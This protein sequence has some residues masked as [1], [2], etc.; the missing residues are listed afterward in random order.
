MCNYIHCY[1]DIMLIHIRNFLSFLL[2]WFVL[3]PFL[4][5]WGNASSIWAKCLLHISVLLIFLW[6][7]ALNQGNT[8]GEFS[9]TYRIMY[10]LFSW[11]VN[12]HKWG[13]LYLH[14]SLQDHT[15]A[16][17]ILHPNNF[18]DPWILYSGCSHFSVMEYLT[19]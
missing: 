1:A 13:Q 3:K 7:A 11:G 15:N 9:F 4:R 19:L 17:I 18:R 14:T 12:F 16:I 5:A 6:I 8:I 10:V 2:Y